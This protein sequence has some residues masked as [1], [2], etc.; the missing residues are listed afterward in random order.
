MDR[1]R[2]WSGLSLVEMDDLWEEAKAT[3]AKPDV[4]D[5]VDD[6]SA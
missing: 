2:E 3:F 5:K 1:G 4:A 6:E